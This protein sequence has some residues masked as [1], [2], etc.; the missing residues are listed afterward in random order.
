[1]DD[2]TLIR[3][4]L[5]LL[6]KTGFPDDRKKYWLE[7][8]GSDEPGPDDEKNFTDELRAHLKTLD[9][10]IG[11]TEAQIEA[12]RAKI[13]ALDTQ[14]LPYLQRLAQAQP[15]YYEQESA[16]YKKEILAAEKQ[17]MTEVEGVRGQSQAEEIEAIRKK[18]LS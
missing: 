11:F 5:E 18:L 8:L 12:D 2:K 1:M 6:D 7:R 16:R 4:F 15:E 13:E 14:A 10:A 9:E 17:M 3:N